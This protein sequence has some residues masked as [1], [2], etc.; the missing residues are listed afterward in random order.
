MAGV[1]SNQIAILKDIVEI[2]C[3]TLTIGLTR[4]S[5]GTPLNG[6]FRGFCEMS[7]SRCSGYSHEFAADII[8]F[9]SE[10]TPVRPQ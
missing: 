2:G 10:L 4:R 5:F 7:T 6:I 1:S 3:A 8:E 9:P